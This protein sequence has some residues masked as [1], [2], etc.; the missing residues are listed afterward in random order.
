MPRK[1]VLKISRGEARENA[2]WFMRQAGRYLKEYQEIK[3]GRTFNDLLAD[4]DAIYHL[5]VLPTKY[6]KTDA[7]VI[8]TDILI[9]LGLM[10][11]KVS[12]EN[13]INVTSGDTD[14]KELP[15]GLSQAIK[16]VSRDYGDLTIIG[17][18]GGPYTTLSYIYEKGKAG[19]HLAKREV[20]ER[21]EVL[22]SQV[23]EN[24]LNFGKLQAD[25]GVDVIQIFESWLGS[26]SETF[27]EMHVKQWEEY[28]VEK[29]REL[30][31]PVIFFSEGTSHLSR[32]LS[33]LEADV[34]SVDWR[35]S[36]NRYLEVYGDRVVQ[37][38]LDP[39]LLDSPD[40]Y[41]RKEVRRIMT[42]GKSFKGHVFNLGHGVPK[43]ANWSKLS[44]VADEV[45]NFDG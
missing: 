29:V 23:I 45:H 21:G 30:G 40:I 33:R 39:D 43:W 7:I 14:Y 44:F 15:Q 10:G 19:Y 4:P 22:M 20:L 11:Y 17:V 35:Q 18:L 36:L 6:I 16:M 5:S 32:A 37:G 41:L 12:Y 2:V 13:G 1:T 24:T 38:N 42:E 34:F 31:K 26:L 3:R 9:P 25:S 28:F 8:F 27:Y